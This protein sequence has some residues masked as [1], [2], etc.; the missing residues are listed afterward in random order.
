MRNSSSTRLI[1]YL[2]ELGA[3]VKYLPFDFS[4]S[5]A[6]QYAAIEVIT[7]E[8]VVGDL[9]VQVNSRLCRENGHCAF[10]RGLQISD[11]G[12]GKYKYWVEIVPFDDVVG[13]EACVAATTQFLR[14]LPREVKNFKC[15]GPSGKERRRGR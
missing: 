3:Q 1:N 10:L 11:G 5:H 4:D 13:E 9:Q 15:V 8:L 2:S 14:S 12:N 6:P 7:T